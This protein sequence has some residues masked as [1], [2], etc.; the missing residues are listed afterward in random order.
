MDPQKCNQGVCATCF[1]GFI[2]NV[3]HPQ[4]EADALGIRHINRD[5]YTELLGIV[6]M[7][8]PASVVSTWGYTQ[9]AGHTA[10]APDQYEI[11]YT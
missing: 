8:S 3:I 9:C 5:V 6:G 4:V 7:S 10:F 11:S 2:H 1:V